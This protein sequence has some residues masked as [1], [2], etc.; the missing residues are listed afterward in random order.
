LRK[1]ISS[2]ILALLLS[3]LFVF[4]SSVQPVK[5]QDTIYILPDGTINPQSAN[6]TKDSRSIMYMF[7]GNNYLPISVH[8]SNIIINGMGYTVQ[9]SEGNGLFLQSVNN[10]TVE[11]TKI[12]GSAYGIVLGSSS[13]NIVS[14]NNVTANTYDGI[15]LSSS[16]NNTI[17]ANTATE[18]GHGIELDSSPSNTITG[19]HITAN[20]YHGIFLD[21]SSNNTISGNN[22]TANG[23]NNIYLYSSSNNTITGNNANSAGEST[24]NGI[25]LWTSSNNTISGNNVTANG[26]NGIYLYSNSD[27]N[28]LSDNS[29]T[30]NSW[31]TTDN[32]TGGIMLK[33]S[34]SNWIIGNNVTANGHKGIELLF[35]SGNT[36]SGNKVVGNE[37][38]SI[39]LWFSSNNTVNGN[40]VTTGHYNGI[41]VVS[42][43]NSRIIGNTVTDIIENL[44]FDGYGI[45]VQSSLNCT[46][47]GNSVSGSTLDGIKFFNCSE[48]RVIG[49][50]VTANGMNGV[51]LLIS[52]NNTISG[53]NA[54]A[55][56][57][58]G[59]MLWTSSNNTISGNNAT[60]NSRNGI[61]L[62]SYS[63][64]NTLSGNHIAEN[65]GAGILLNSSSSNLI[66]HNNFIDN[67]VQVS[68]DLDSRGDY[69][70]DG[71]PSGG[72]YWSDY[73]GIDQKSG[74]GQ[75]LAGSDGIGDTFYIINANNRDDYPLMEAY[76]LLSVAISPESATLDVGGFTLFTS[77]VTGGRTPYVYQWCLNGAVVSGA[78]GSSW[79][80]TPISP[81]SYD[82]YLNVTDA[83]SA[84]ATSNTAIVI[85]NSALVA[86]TVT[87]SPSTVDQ[88]QT[89]IL[90]SSVV[91]TGTPPYA[92]QWFMMAPGESEYSAIGG[93]TL[94]SYSFVTSVSTHI[95]VWHFELNVTDDTGAVVTSNA[96]T[97]TVS[98]LTTLIPLSDWEMDPVYS[99]ASYVL[100]STLSSLYLELDAIDTTS[101]VTIFNSNIPKL[102][103]TG[104]TYVSVAVSG[105]ENAK[106]LLRF[107]LDD[108]SCFDVVYWGSPTVLGVTKFDLS[109][110]AGRTLSGVVYMS[111]KSSDGTQA[112]ITITQ[113][114]F[115]TQALP[116]TIPLAA[117]Q[118]DPAY[119]NAPYVLNSNP[120]SLYVELDATDT[121]S[122]VTIFN[123]SIPKLKLS[124]FAYVSVTVT[125]SENA[126]ILLRF[127]LD[128]G[129]CFDVVYWGTPAALNA[130]RFDLSPYAARTL[131][132]IVY[133][134]LM[135]SDGAPANITITQIAFST[136]ALPPTI[137]LSGWSEDPA[138]TNAFYVLNSNPSSLYLELEA[139]D[140]ASRVTIFNPSI[141]K[142]KLSDYTYVSVMVA[143]TDNARILLRFFL[144]D[145][146]C[147]DVVYWQSPAI[148]NATRFDLT[149]Y[150]ARTLSGV[151]YI[152]LMSSDGAPANITITQIAFSTQALPSTIPLSGW[153]EDPLYTNASYV[154]NSN[155]SSIYLQL[156][157][158]DTSSRVTIFNS[159]IPKLSLSD[160]TYVNV[161]VS[162]S[163]NARIL[164]RFF[165]DDGS[166]FDVVYWGNPAVLNATEFDLSPYAGR[167]LS[168]VYVALMSSDGT[169]ANITITQI[170][171]VYA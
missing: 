4:A 54:E 11:N 62:Y 3:S 125:G 45:Q 77:S 168:E 26:W 161:T 91:S 82:V 42:A 130:I 139:T 149:P 23:W 121:S 163:D 123:P 144:D 124:D 90:S 164:L 64:N 150:G 128:D 78:T 165:M 92:Y 76:S 34:S 101:R 135:S 70:D 72:N 146:S 155:P 162:G 47:S 81:S 13:G 56:S 136:Q 109:P 102:S 28:T 49:N 48:S 153:E 103:L 132:G 46:V 117:W 171:F 61:Y 122:R 111:L 145:G 126:K 142:L 131:S 57:H 52:S 60:A 166:C 137:P 99:N 160:Y 43:S 71:Y 19:N 69:W 88:S 108:G 31:A 50:S 21:S 106:I 58:D 30:A 51:Y 80:F 151:V 18:N 94:T 41:Y 24:S 89:S 32:S 17:I 87:A 156:D 68:I 63:N 20:S 33:N 115:T 7:T 127:F 157:A 1:I 105:S 15:Y 2:L 140:T 55:N 85:V 98:A 147:F 143:G 100:N 14:G 38:D 83:T 116:S 133:I 74:P 148:L 170:D 75:N 35:S 118:E 159:N 114:A 110:Y 104:Y 79:T 22:A 141:P 65:S 40:N 59:I 37:E 97:V 169:T 96:A 152:S 25:M 107:F 95:G 8:R 167:A 39:E 27:G 154:L 86:P 112:N 36:A 12:T 53:N 119:T 6:I 93:A 134:S 44:D 120:S 29:V 10:V 5:A 138:Y 9:A 84:A 16:S 129:S 158:I 66:Y 113:V 73:S 67:S